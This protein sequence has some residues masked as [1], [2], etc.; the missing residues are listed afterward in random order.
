VTGVQNDEPAV[1]DP[2]VE[3]LGVLEQ[4]DTVVI[5]VDDVTGSMNAK[6][7]LFARTSEISPPK[8]C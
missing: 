3:E 7:A 6:R 1:G 4:D 2:L 8:R 5:A